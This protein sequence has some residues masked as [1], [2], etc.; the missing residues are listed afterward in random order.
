MIV[1]EALAVRRRKRK[2]KHDLELVI[3]ITDT[4]TT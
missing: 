2:I 1:K 4:H 3:S